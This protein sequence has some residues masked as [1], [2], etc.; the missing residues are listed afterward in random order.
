[1]GRWSRLIH[2]GVLKES[3][4]CQIEPDISHVGTHLKVNSSLSAASDTAFSL[5]PQFL[6]D[7][8]QLSQPNTFGLSL[9]NLSGVA[10][11]Q[12]LKA[13]NFQ[14]MRQAYL[15][16]LAIPGYLLWRP[17]L[18]D[19]AYLIVGTSIYDALVVELTPFAAPASQTERRNLRWFRV[20]RSSAEKPE[21]LPITNP[22]GWK[23]RPLVTVPP[24]LMP[25]SEQGQIGL[26]PERN[27]YSGF[28]WIHGLRCKVYHGLWLWVLKAR[29]R[30]YGL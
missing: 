28:E 24:M 7:M 18:G 20:T 5:G 8:I 25:P 12:L 3:G 2:S 14:G 17:D 15:S 21:L 13:D 19:R 16:L 9:Y 22:S 1:M 10:T 4:R 23:S 27:G 29:C 30:V 26:R 11:L 6:K